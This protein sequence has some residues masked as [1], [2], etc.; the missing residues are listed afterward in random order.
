MRAEITGRLVTGLGEAGAFTQLDWAR[1]HF[2][3]KLGIDP[4]PGT[5]NLELDD[6]VELARWS[7]IRKSPGIVMATPEPDW[8]DCRCFRVRINGEIAGAVV[9]PEVP[10]Y[11]E[12]KIELIAGVGVRDRLG[13]ADGDAVTIEFLDD[14]ED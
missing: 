9:L 2:I 7:E 1:R 14:G 6:A 3:A 13:I 4:F 11:P 5:V 8:C 12:E 10:D